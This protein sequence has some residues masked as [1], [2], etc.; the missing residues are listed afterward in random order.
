MCRSP[1]PFLSRC[2]RLFLQNPYPQ[3]SGTYADDTAEEEEEETAEFFSLA[4]PPAPS[5]RN[6]GARSGCLHFIIRSGPS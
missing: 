4:S 5:L 1:R 2:P 6:L 3:S